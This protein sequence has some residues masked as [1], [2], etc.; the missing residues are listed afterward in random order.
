MSIISVVMIAAFT[1]IYIITYTNIQN[2]N[3]IKLTDTVMSRIM[4]NPLF[5]AD[6]NNNTDRIFVGKIPNDYASAFNVLIGDDNA[7][8]SI[9]SYID[10]ADEIYEKATELAISAKKDSSVISLGSRRWLY[11]INPIN[12]SLFIREKGNSDTVAKMKAIKQIYFLDVTDSYKILSQLLFTFGAISVVMLFVIFGI[13]LFF[14]QHAVAPIEKAYEKQ[15]QFIADA[16]HELKTPIAI[17]NANI[18][19]LYV[20]KTETIESQ[21]KWLNYINAETDRMGK[22]VSDLLY[23]AKTDNGVVNNELFPFNISNIVTDVLLAMEAVIF[24]K[25]IKLSHN[26]EPNIIA[27]GDSEKVKQVVMI[28]LDNAVKYVNENGN[29]FVTLKKSRNNTAFSVKNTGNGIPKQSLSKLFD[30]FYRMDS[31]RTHDGG[32]GLGLSI[33]KEIIDSM[34]GKIQVESVEGK[35]TAFTFI[36]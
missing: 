5:N 25:G 33:A 16:S 20:N 2:E 6:E 31:S 30:R 21:Q 19:A 13:S 22:L 34:G 8:L 26:I 15:K 17:I 12:A 3:Q 18:D 28:L 23:L 14:A 36:L 29:I 7:L 9:H 11:K 35:S 27:N 32:Y 1:A 24:E 4:I 10:L